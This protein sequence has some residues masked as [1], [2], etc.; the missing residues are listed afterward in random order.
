MKVDTEKIKVLFEKE[1]PYRIAKDTGLAVS[2]VQRLAKGERKLEN[3]SIR[4]GAT[5][6][7]YARKHIGE[8]TK[9][10]KFYI[11]INEARKGAIQI[12]NTFYEV[13]SSY[14]E[15]YDTISNQMIGAGS[16][17]D[18]TYYEDMY[19]EQNFEKE[20]KKAQKQDKVSEFFDEMF[21]GILKERD[22]KELL[23][24]LKASFIEFEPEEELSERIADKERK[25]SFYGEG[26]KKLAEYLES[27]SR[28]DALLVITYYYLYF[29]Y[30][31]MV[32]L[33]SDIQDEQ[34]E[35]AIVV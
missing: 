6:T 20:Y 27:L 35:Y 16:S 21:N 30:N 23:T 19:L 3:A 1:N 9:M 32:Q 29:G 13:A 26:L 33:I 2:V 11:E 7:E 17:D 4:V 8:D 34:V 25:S 18:I 24:L 12:G 14:K 5:L 15:V 22:Y 10:K 31:Y 28:E